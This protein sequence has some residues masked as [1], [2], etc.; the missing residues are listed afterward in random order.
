ML[1]TRRLILRPWKREDFPLFAAINAD[2]RVMEFFP[3]VLSREESDA[4]ALRL[5]REIEE[6]GWG[7]WAAVLSDSQEFIGFIGISYRTHQSLPVSFT[8][9][10][11]IGWRLAF[12]YWGKGYATEGALAVLKYGFE[13]LRLDEIVSFTAA[14]N[15]RSR[16]LMERIG[17]HRDPKDDFDHP[18]IPEGHW[19]RRHVLY[20]LRRCYT[21]VNSKL[22]YIPIL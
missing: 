9:A 2:S 10:V 19:L 18:K 14:Q 20:R 7:F 21:Q 3:S 17:M 13:M 4:I 16:R 6:K 5:Q 22:G 8:P 1:T 15:N 12:E 11:E